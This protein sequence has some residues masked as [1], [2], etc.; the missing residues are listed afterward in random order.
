MSRQIQHS[1]SRDTRKDAR[2]R[3]SACPIFAVSGLLLLCAGC[4]NSKEHA[5]EPDAFPVQ[6]RVDIGEAVEEPASGTHSQAREMNVSDQ[7]SGLS[8]LDLPT[9]LPDLTESPH[10]DGPMEGEA[11]EA[12]EHVETGS[13][14]ALAAGPVADHPSRLTVN[15]TVLGPLSRRAVEGG[16]IHVSPDGTRYAYWIHQ[17]GRFA[18]IV[19]GQIGETVDRVEGRGVQA[20]QTVHG[21]VTRARRPPVES[22]APDII[23]SPD[24]RRLAYIA[25]D[26]PDGPQF[27]VLDGQRH[28]SF[29]YVC[30][31]SARFSPDG[32]RFA[33]LVAEQT[34]DAKYPPESEDLHRC[35]WRLILD[36]QPLE[37]VSDGYS[38]SDHAPVFSPDGR[39][40]AYVRSA[41]SGK[42][43][44]QRWHSGAYVVLDGQ[45]HTSS[46]AGSI[47]QLV[48]SPNSERLAY[49]SRIETGFLN[50]QM[51]CTV[52]LDGK[53]QASYRWIENL[54]F[55]PDSDRL[56]YNA[57][58]DERTQV[59]VVD[60][61][62]SVGH[63]KVSGPVF[64][65]DS[66]RV[67]YHVQDGNAAIVVVDGQE[68]GEY[69]RVF[70]PLVFTADSKY[71]LYLAQSEEDEPWLICR[72]SLSDEAIGRT[73]WKE[74]GFAEVFSEWE[75]RRSGTEVT[76]DPF[77]EMA[78]LLT[79][80][81]RSSSFIWAVWT[82]SESP[83][84]GAFD[85]FEEPSMSVCWEDRVIQTFPAHRIEDFQLRLDG[86][87]LYFPRR[88]P[89][90]DSSS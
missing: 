25:Q 4:W 33:Y 54:V 69:A 43:I 28:A 74:L 55:S 59:V 56:A 29:W 90:R 72:V 39:R 60:G 75:D 41:G 31:Q 46:E 2:D 16:P 24:S 49:V 38:F 1:R 70:D 85:S 63:T 9:T 18:I 19:D 81:P 5:Q 67:A 45:R 6:R 50:R 30:K 53:P 89:Q 10:R 26:S 88:C 8:G 82:V 15:D 61:R 14:D 66:R 83:D 58:K 44:E 13:R 79:V 23:F 27:V 52:V 68:T 86:N 12:V 36:G 22:R 71:L 78:G 40:L 21:L 80:A 77:H 47:G 3:Q 84:S 20:K 32:Q 42:T 48:F 62:E 34:S 11:V 17:G 64:S 87:R 7:A 37:Q 35:S 51:E 57:W 76:Y 73:E 65:P